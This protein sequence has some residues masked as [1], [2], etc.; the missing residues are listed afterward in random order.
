MKSFKLLLMAALAVGGCGQTLQTHGM[1][2]SLG[3]NILLHLEGKLELLG[4]TNV[5]IVIYCQFCSQIQLS[6]LRRNYIF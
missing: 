3:L 2:P 1:W 4:Q 5:Y 6:S